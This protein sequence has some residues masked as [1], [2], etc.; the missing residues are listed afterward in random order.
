MRY[1][2]DGSTNSEFVSLSYSTLILKA[3]GLYKDLSSDSKANPIHYGQ[4]LN[5]DKQFQRGDVFD[6]T[7]SG[8]VGLCRSRLPNNNLES[9]TNTDRDGNIIYIPP[10]GSDKQI[11]LVFDA[12]NLQRNLLKLNKNDL[13][14]VYIK[15]DQK[16]LSQ[17]H[18][19]SEF[20]KELIVADCTN[21]KIIYHPVCGRYSRYSGHYIKSCGTGG[22]N[23]LARLPI[24]YQ[25]QYIYSW[26]QLLNKL[27]FKRD[28]DCMNDQDTINSSDYSNSIKS[29]YSANDAAGL[30]FTVADSDTINIKDDSEY[31][32]VTTKNFSSDTVGIKGKIPIFFDKQDSIENSVSKVSNKY[33][34]LKFLNNIHNNNSA[35]TGGY[36]LYVQHSTCQSLNGK[37]IDDGLSNNGKIEY[38]IKHGSTDFISSSINGNV[39]VLNSDNKGSINITDDNSKIFLRIKNDEENYI[40][41]E[42]EYAISWGDNTALLNPVT[43]IFKPL[44][45]DFINIIQHNVRNYFKNITCYS[46]VTSTEEV[47]SDCIDFFL[48]IKNILTI[49]IIVYTVMFLFAMV[50]IN[51]TEL[52]IHISKIA[53][54]AGLISGQTF[55]F[56]NKYIFDLVI[57]AGDELIQS[58]NGQTGGDPFDFLTSIFTQIFFSEVFWKQIFALFAIG[59]HGVVYVALVL[60]IVGIVSYVSIKVIV[61]YLAAIFVLGVLLTLSPI[62][63]VFLLFDTTKSLFY[64]WVNR[65]FYYI[66]EPV[67]ML[68]GVIMLMKLFMYFLDSILGYSVC[69][70]CA[71]PIYLSDIVLGIPVLVDI[72]EFI[73]A[74]HP[75]FCLQLFMP[76][77]LEFTDVMNIS[78]GEIVTLIMIG[79]V[80]FE[81]TGFISNTLNSLLD[82]DGNDLFSNVKN[83][84]LTH[85]IKRP[86][87]IVKAPFVGL[88]KIPLAMSSAKRRRARIVNAS[89]ISVEIAGNVAAKLVKPVESSLYG[90]EYGAKKIFNKISGKESTIKTRLTPNFL[91]KSITDKSLRFSSR[92]KGLSV[93]LKNTANT[94]AAVGYMISHPLHTTAIYSYKAIKFAGNKIWKSQPV[95][96]IRAS[97]KEKFTSKKVRI[98]NY[99]R[100]AVNSIDQ[101]TKNIFGYNVIQTRAFKANNTTVKTSYNVGRNLYKFSKNLYHAPRKFIDNKLTEFPKDNSKKLQFNTKNSK[102]NS[103]KLQSNTKDSKDNN[104]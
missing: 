35:N 19:I 73:T 86:S 2:K 44:K 76:W 31:D 64:N 42:G 63:L 96:N 62:F 11:S 47:T 41:S 28:L 13:I 7:V 71:L 75:L 68:T 29:W 45:E 70:K 74:G 97:M 4:W 95:S 10:V 57:K 72:A 32:I 92:T 58:I 65:I 51:T 59:I 46:D 100:S 104:S 23:E 81:Y 17:V 80:M 101:S 43:S 37:G 85:I 93:S 14:S 66:L 77:G 30:L 12:K 3:N 9:N 5:V 48:Y 50:N 53:I 69:I 89:R 25:D 36:I 56:F 98:N 84:F 99:A 1:G 94:Y 33:L 83:A 26:S 102:D 39:A 49:Y 38:L 78:F 8:R 61:S 90:I 6:F 79:V 82:N 67:I 60:S 40:H 34:Q 16:S 87:Q 22:I 88:S 18:Y 91:S 24:P 20:D 103:K 21:N 54:I 15:P 55:E 52:I 27:D